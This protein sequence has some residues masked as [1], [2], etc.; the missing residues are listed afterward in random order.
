MCTE[1]KHT[2]THTDTHRQTQSTTPR[3]YTSYTLSRV[4]LTA[5]YIHTHTDIYINT[6]TDAVNYS[7]GIYKL[8]ADAERALSIELTATYIHTHTH[9][10]THNRRGQLL[11]GDI[12]A[13][14]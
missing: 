14:R 2:Y 13:I 4:E 7:P 8:Y 5:I 10:H 3:G 12:Q 9:I 1:Y 6:Q 11:S